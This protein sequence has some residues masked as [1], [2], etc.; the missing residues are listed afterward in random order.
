MRRAATA[1]WKDAIT[2]PG[3]LSTRLRIEC[4]DPPT[5]QDKCVNRVTVTKER[6]ALGRPPEN[7]LDVF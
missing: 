5:I 1:A 2:A 6:A 7:I 3:R 4:A